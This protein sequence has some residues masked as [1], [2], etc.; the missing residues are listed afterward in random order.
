MNEFIAWVR[1]T[2]PWCRSNSW[3]VRREFLKRLKEEFDT[4]GIEIPFPHVTLYA[5]AG[6]DGS[7]PPFPVL[8]IQANAPSAATA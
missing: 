4:R 6:K 2:R 3:G 5:G 8:S 1:I 7:A